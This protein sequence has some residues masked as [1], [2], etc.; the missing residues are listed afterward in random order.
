MS[1]ER[2]RL[3]K[4]LLAIWTAIT[5]WVYERKFKSEYVIVYLFP[6]RNGPRNVV[7]QNKLEHYA[8]PLRKMASLEG[9][10]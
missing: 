6:L 4:G 2:I 5:W 8:T 7:L 3:L 1:L 9:N 10:L